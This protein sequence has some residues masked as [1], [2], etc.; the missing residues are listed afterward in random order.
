M[1]NIVV[2]LNSLEYD[3]YF[4]SA[5]NQAKKTTIFMKLNCCFMK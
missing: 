5:L 1:P 2:T 4:V 3:G